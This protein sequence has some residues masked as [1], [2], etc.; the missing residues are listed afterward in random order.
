MRFMVPSLG[1][2]TALVSSAVQATAANWLYTSDLDAD[3]QVTSP[4]HY[5]S[6]QLWIQLQD[7]SFS[8]IKNPVPKYLR[9]PNYNTMTAT[10]SLLQADGW[11][12]IGTRMSLPVS[13]ICS[14]LLRKLLAARSMASTCE[15]P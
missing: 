15:K 11:Q 4:W 1:G 12:C 3:G 13:S 5:T 2:G 6:K 8:P 14:M 10:A 7:R 9:R